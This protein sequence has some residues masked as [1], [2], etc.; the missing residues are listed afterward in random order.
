MLRYINDKF[1]I[2]HKEF[3]V[4]IDD[5]ENWDHQILRTQTKTFEFKI[6][7]KNRHI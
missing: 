6:R 3:T 4:F 1:A 2:T 5:V 7:Y